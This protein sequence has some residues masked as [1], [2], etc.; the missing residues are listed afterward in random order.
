MRIFLI[1]QKKLAKKNPEEISKMILRLRGDY[2]S[3]IYMP[4]ESEEYKSCLISHEKKY[5]CNNDKSFYQR[6]FSIFFVFN[7]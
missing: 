1:K 5:N 6:F 7:D 2:A 3:I 4:L